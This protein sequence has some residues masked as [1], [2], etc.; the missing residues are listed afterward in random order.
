[1]CVCACART[2]RIVSM[3]KILCFTY[4]LLII[5]YDYYCIYDYVL[6]FFS[7]KVENV[8]NKYSKQVS[9]DGLVRADAAVLRWTFCF[10]SFFNNT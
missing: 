1:M 2:L 9:N 10:S 8:R 7:S 3:D 5:F 4:A 6:I